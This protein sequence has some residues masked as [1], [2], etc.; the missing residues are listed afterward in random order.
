MNIDLLPNGTEVLTPDGTG[1]VDSSFVAFGIAHYQV[2]L[3]ETYEVKPYLRHELESES[4]VG[5]KEATLKMDEWRKCADNP[6]Y[7]Y[8]NYWEILNNKP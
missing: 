4:V 2:K 5:W 6:S 8:E 1:I 7:F 3:F